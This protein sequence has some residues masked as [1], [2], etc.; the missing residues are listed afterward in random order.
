LE[1]K[2]IGFALL[3]L[4]HPEDMRERRYSSTHS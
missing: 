1:N 2:S 4:S 3:S